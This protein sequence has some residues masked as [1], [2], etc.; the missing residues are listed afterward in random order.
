MKMNLWGWALLSLGGCGALVTCSGGVQ[1]QTAPA[2][3]QQTV[4]AQVQATV[5]A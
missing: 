1:P 2:N 4:S 3:V 5:G